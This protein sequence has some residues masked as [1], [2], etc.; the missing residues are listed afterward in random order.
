MIEGKPYNDDTTMHYGTWKG[1]LFRDI[2][3]DYLL[4]LWRNKKA[5]GIAL[6]SYIFDHMDE[7][8]YR[9]AINSGRYI[10]KK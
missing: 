7:L 2:P 1:H 6:K 8:T 4:W 3:A 9:N 5:H 10:I